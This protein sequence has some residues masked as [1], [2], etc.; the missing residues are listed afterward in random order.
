[1]GTK[2]RGSVPTAPGAESFKTSS[3]LRVATVPIPINE[4]IVSAMLYLHLR[5][6]V[7]S[8]LCGSATTP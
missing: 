2:V 3:V 6:T 1:M 8:L 4:A 7:D 5:L